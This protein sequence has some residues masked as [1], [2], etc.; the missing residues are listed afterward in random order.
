MSQ[1]LTDQW[2]TFPLRVYY[3]DTDAQG[4]VYFANYLK[5]MER[6]RTEW[7]RESGV[8]QAVLA[9]RHRLGFTVVD[10]AIRFRHPA[11]YSDQLVVCTRLAETRGVRFTLEQEVRRAKSQ[12]LLCGGHCVVACID[13]DSFKPRRIATAIKLPDVSRRRNRD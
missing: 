10:T 5:F 4:V 12:E 2:H 8:D 1:S 7:L 3:E 9:D 13:L 6:G 11:R